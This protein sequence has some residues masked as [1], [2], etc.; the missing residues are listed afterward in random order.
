MH[1]D[2][3]ITEWLQLTVSPLYQG[4]YS[5][6]FLLWIIK[7]SIYLYHVLAIF[8]SHISPLGWN[9][10][11][12]K[13]GWPIHAPR[14]SAI[15]VMYSENWTNWQHDNKSMALSMIA[16]LSV[17]FEM[18]H[19]LCVGKHLMDFG[20]TCKILSHLQYA[21][22]NSVKVLIG[23]VH[24]YFKNLLGVKW[25]MYY[26]HTLCFNQDISNILLIEIEIEQVHVCQSCSAITI[27]HMGRIWWSQWGCSR[28]AKASDTH[29]SSLV[30]YCSGRD[31]L[32]WWHGSH[33]L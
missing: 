6:R 12:R 18:T 10:A 9:E 4:R 27:T 31:Y 7:G 23:W 2:R 20:F 19:K 26:K 15:I 11:R 29:C 3:A 22:S 24:N 17:Q 28:D 25:Q 30:V 32:R 14:I 21:W 33:A 13:I 1:Y 5:S 8:I 16:N